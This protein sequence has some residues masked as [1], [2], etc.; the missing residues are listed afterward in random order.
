MIN[1]QYLIRQLMYHNS[2]F[3]K[4]FLNIHESTFSTLFLSNS[5]I[6]SI[7]KESSQIRRMLSKAEYISTRHSYKF[8]VFIKV[9]TPFLNP[10]IK[11]S[12]Y[13]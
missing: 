9:T 6:V 8:K 1:T 2:F 10:I 7:R 4:L 13:R 11:T 5:Q 3:K 12:K